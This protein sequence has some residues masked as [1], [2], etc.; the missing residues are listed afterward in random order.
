MLL[1]SP[2]SKNIIQPG[3]MKTIVVWRK[4]Q[5][6]CGSWVSNCFSVFSSKLIGS[7]KA[8]S[9]TRYC[10][11]Y[12][13]KMLAFTTTRKTLRHRFIYVKK[14]FTVKIEIKPRRGVAA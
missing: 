10:H 3:G 4:V 8:V 1:T 7:I 2:A 5:I 9:E 14:M 6:Y 11:F 12:A 13:L